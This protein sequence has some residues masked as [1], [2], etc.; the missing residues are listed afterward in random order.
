MKAASL[1]HQYLTVKSTNINDSYFGGGR[2]RGT[3]KNQ[4]Q[5]LDSEQDRTSTPATDPLSRQSTTNPDAST[6]SVA[7]LGRS[8]SES[9][10]PSVIYERESTKKAGYEQLHEGILIVY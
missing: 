5:L 4:R 2:F 10:T 3:R 6:P 9:N 7:I 8:V 1:G